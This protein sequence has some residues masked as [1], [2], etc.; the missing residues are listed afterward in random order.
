MRSPLF[1]SR[2]QRRPGGQQPILTHE[3]IHGSRTEPGGQRGVRGGGLS[4]RRRLLVLAE[5][6]LHV[7]KYGRGTGPVAP[8]QL[9]SRAIPK[10]PTARI[11]SRS[12]GAGNRRPP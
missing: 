11:T 5:Q 12:A 3:L 9:T 10:I 7:I 6:A 4:R 8:A 1:Q 2:P